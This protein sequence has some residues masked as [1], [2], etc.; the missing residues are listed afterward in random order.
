MVDIV[1]RRSSAR[2]SMAFAVGL[3]QDYKQYKFSVSSVLSFSWN[4]ILVPRKARADPNGAILGPQ[5]RAAD[6]NSIVR[7][8]F[9][10]CPNASVL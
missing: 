10:A 9:M 4:A 2:L 7:Q 5:E 3:R 8:V 6:S 1:T